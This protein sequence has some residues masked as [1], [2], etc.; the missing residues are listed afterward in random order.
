MWTEGALQSWQKLCGASRQRAGS[1]GAVRR[2]MCHLR[3][4]TLVSDL[5]A[6]RERSL[7]M[8]AAGTGC[9]GLCRQLHVVKP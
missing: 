8:R 1:F 2:R 5:G 6:L 3:V 7:G 9:E 4:L